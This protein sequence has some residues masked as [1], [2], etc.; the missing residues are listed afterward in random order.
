MYAVSSQIPYSLYV[1]LITNVCYELTVK[2][3]CLLF[4]VMHRLKDEDAV[5]V[6][7]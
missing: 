7:I 4:N 2:S 5:L 1:F 3:E 6:C